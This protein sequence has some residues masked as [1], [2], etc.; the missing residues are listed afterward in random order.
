MRKE[1]ASFDYLSAL[2][3]AKIGPALNLIHA[4]ELAEKSVEALA[5]AVALS[6]SAF[7]E[8][9]NKLVGESPKTYLVNWRMQKAKSKLE[10]T[11][12]NM[13]NIA[14]AAGYASEA[15]FSKAFKQHF[16]VTPG[17]IRKS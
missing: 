15:A 11:K 1:N 14:E 3:D 5:N 12:L 7:T 2:S 9:F 17:S 10:Q 8:R 4:E 6:R 13:H 16:N